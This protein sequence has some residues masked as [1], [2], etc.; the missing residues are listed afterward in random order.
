MALPKPSSSVAHCHSGTAMIAS[1]FP[2]L[3]PPSIVVDAPPPTHSTCSFT[4]LPSG[5]LLSLQDVDAV[6]VRARADGG[7]GHDGLAADELGV[8]ERL[9]RLD[10]PVPQ[11]LAHHDVGV[12]AARVG[13]EQHEGVLALLG[14]LQRMVGVAQ[15]EHGLAGGQRLH[16]LGP[17]ARDDEARQAE[18]FFLEKLLL[19]RHQVL[20]VHERRNAV[21][22][23]DRLALRVGRA[24]AG[25][26]AGRRPSRSWWRGIVGESS[27]STILLGG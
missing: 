12:G 6:D 8:G 21:R 9:D 24:P 1:N 16:H 17:A 22:R 11:L 15:R 26:P 7:G 23:G 5:A 3:S 27:S 2:A 10:A 18:P 13:R 19:L 14:D 25:R 20:A 4:V